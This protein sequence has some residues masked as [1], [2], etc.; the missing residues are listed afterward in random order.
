[1]PTRNGFIQGYNA[2]NVITA[3][4]LILATRLTQCPNDVTFYQPMINEAVA[5]AARLATHR[6][7]TGTG[8]G[9]GTGTDPTQIGLVL[10]DAGYLSTDNLTTPGPDRLIATGKHRTLLH[11]ARDH[12]PPA[13]TDPDPTDPHPDSQTDPADP[14]TAMT[15]RL[16]TPEGITAY[17]QRSHLAETPHGHLKHNMRFSQLCLR[18]LPRANAEWT[19]ATA[20]ANLFKALPHAA[21]HLPAT[22]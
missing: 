10:A 1:M 6:P 9:T 20:T 4:G 15:Q 3:D 19:F 18:G 14:I 2:Q 8:T 17:N 7:T 13:Q 12:T 5:T 16:R 22:P 21:R 11:A